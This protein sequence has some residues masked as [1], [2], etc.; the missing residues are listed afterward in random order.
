MTNQNPVI[1][2]LEKL[3][4]E[5]F[6][7]DVPSPQTDLLE[8]GILDSFQFVELLMQLEQDFGFKVDIESIDL[9]NLRTLEKIA[10]LVVQ[11]GGTLN[12]SA[13][14]TTGDALA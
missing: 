3:F 5:T 9:D 4:A 14:G 11:S 1:S 13:A 12:H 8:Q 2:R 6:H 7:L 10:D